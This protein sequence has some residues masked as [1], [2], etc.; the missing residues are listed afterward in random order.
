MNLN[1]SPFLFD[2]TSFVD[3]I[4]WNMIHDRCSLFFSNA[5]VCRSYVCVCVCVCVCVYVEGYSC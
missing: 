1:L 3:C 2:V 5:R 4:S